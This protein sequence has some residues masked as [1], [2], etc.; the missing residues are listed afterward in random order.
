MAELALYAIDGIMWVS[1]GCGHILL[2][3]FVAWLL[4]TSKGHTAAYIWYQLVNIH[5]FEE[6]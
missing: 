4:E 6:V 3:L 5:I 1:Q 2:S